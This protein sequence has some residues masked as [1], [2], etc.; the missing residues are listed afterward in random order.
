M[1]SKDRNGWVAWDRVHLSNGVPVI[2]LTQYNMSG[3]L[4]TKAR[5]GGT[6]D[7]SKVLLMTTPERPT[8][9][10]LV[11]QHA[12]IMDKQWKVDLIRKEYSRDR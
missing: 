10:A 1:L 8:K 5:V 4:I 6:K 9:D 7:V 11:K 2:I 12:T 3:Q